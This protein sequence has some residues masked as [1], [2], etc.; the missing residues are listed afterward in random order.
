MEGLQY[1]DLEKPHFLCENQI[2]MSSTTHINLIVTFKNII[3]RLVE[4]VMF[5]V[6]S[7]YNADD[8]V[9]ING[10]K[11]VRIIRHGFTKTTFY[12]YDTKRKLI[13]RNDKLPHLMLEKTLPQNGDS[14]EDH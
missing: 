9:Y 11:K 4:G 10:T 1:S 12:V 14:N 6:G 13:I 7:D 2:S 3:Q 5:F 8:I